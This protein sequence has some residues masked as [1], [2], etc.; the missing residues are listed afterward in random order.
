MAKQNESI[1]DSIKKQL[2]IVP[3]YTVFDDQIL[4]Y[5]N[6]TFSTLHQLGIGPDTGYE[7]VDNTS[8][9]DDIVIDPRFNLIKTYVGM[10]VKVMFDPPA[11]S[12]ALDALNKQIAEFEWRIITENEAG[13]A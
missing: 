8:T 7:I 11:S 2:G 9:W 10:K 12:F 5:I 6:T 13:D 3:E 1:L 4:L